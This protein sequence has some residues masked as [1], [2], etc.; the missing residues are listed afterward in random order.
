MTFARNLGPHGMDWFHEEI[1]FAGV[2]VVSVFLWVRWNRWQENAYP[3]FS[4]ASHKFFPEKRFDDEG[5]TVQFKVL[6]ISR[7][8]PQRIFG[9]ILSP[10][11][12]L[13]RNLRHKLGLDYLYL[14]I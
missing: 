7:G 4:D 1:G 5:E 2:P 10:L 12:S 3:H 8:T 14:F 9:L 13:S 6:H 11:R